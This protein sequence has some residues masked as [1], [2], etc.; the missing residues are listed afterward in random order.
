MS[1][2]KA[3]EAARVMMNVPLPA[4]V[5]RLGL[6]IAQA[7]KALDMNAVAVAREMAETKVELRDGHEYSM[8]ELGF[9]PSFYA[10]TEAT[11]EAKVAFTIAENTEF[12]IDAGVGVSLPAGPVM[13]AASVNVHY[14]R[15]FSFQVEGSSSVAARIVA[16]P[17][18][19]RL[20][21]RLSELYPDTPAAPPAPTPPA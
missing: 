7:Q 21:E 18:P 2:S 10:F 14:S 4:M 3:I 20:A 5:E 9:T 8:L 16:L 17:P 15:K 19:S 12:G 13:L 1:S 11:I 6:S